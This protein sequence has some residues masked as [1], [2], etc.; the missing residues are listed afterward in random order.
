[1]TRPMVACCLF[2][3]L[4]LVSHIGWTAQQNSSSKTDNEA[5]SELQP[6]PEEQRERQ[7]QERFVQLLK[8]SPRFGTALDRVYGY[9]VE[10]GSLD[11]FIED[12]QQQAKQ[13]DSDGTDWMLLGL[14]EYQRGNDGQAVEAFTRAEEI[15]KDDRIIW[16]ALISY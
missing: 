2:A 5:V 7:I 8:R 4:C 14:F 12:L 15:R 11:R 13:A 3:C 10:R 9:H 1:M 16:D 6:S